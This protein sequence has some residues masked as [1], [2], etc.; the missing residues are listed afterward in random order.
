MDWAAPVGVEDEWDAD[1]REDDPVDTA[2]PESATASTPATA[3]TT[4]EAATAR[5][6]RV[7]RLIAQPLTTGSARA[8]GFAPT[9]GSDV[10]P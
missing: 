4:T 9:S 8:V 10:P 3:M 6:A 5:A 2:G 1:G 7:L